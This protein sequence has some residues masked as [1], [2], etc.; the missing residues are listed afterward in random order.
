MNG[1]VRMAVG[2]YG[3]RGGK[4]GIIVHDFMTFLFVKTV[5]PPLPVFLGQ[6]RS[7]GKFLGETATTLSLP[8]TGR[9]D[10]TAP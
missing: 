7:G 8:S 1:D 10:Q 5:I 4:V 9:A 6:T 2:D 3:W